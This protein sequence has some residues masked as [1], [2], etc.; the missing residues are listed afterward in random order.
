MP[1]NLHSSIRPPANTILIPLKLPPHLTLHRHR[2]FLTPRTSVQ[3]RDSLTTTYHNPFTLMDMS[4]RR[5]SILRMRANLSTRR[6][7]R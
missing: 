3:H 1:L 7:P 5:S 4:R 2:K 6:L